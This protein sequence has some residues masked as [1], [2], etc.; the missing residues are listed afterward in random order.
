[1]DTIILTIGK[2]KTKSFV[3]LSWP[4]SRT[5]VRK[6]PNSFLR[7]ARVRNPVRT[8]YIMNL[9]PCFFCS[10]ALCLLTCLSSPTEKKG[11]GIR[12]EEEMGKGEQENIREATMCGHRSASW[13]HL[14]SCTCSTRYHKTPDTYGFWYM[15]S[16]TWYPWVSDD[17]TRHDTF[18]Y[19]IIPDTIAPGTH[20]Y[21]MIHRYQAW[22]LMHLIPMGI[23]WYY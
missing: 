19:H 10:Y 3:T 5:Y 6:T 14:W 23:G 20:G 4:H 7:T 22:Y 1:M 12:W 9:I 21:R 2:K 17:T 8:G 15:I 16:C 18:K 11:R 13:Q